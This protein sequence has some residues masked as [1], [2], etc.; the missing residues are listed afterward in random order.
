MFRNLFDWEVLRMI[1][2][3][4]VVTVVVIIVGRLTAWAVGLL[5]GGS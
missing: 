2:T 4:C 5:F 1:P 3:I